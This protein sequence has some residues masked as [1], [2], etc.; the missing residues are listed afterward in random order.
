[1]GFNL[2]RWERLSFPEEMYPAARRASKGEKSDL[3]AFGKVGGRGKPQGLASARLCS[4][5]PPKM[6]TL[7][8]V[9]SLFAA[10]GNVKQLQ[11]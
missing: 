10:S 5:A 7:A 6:V 3:P 4:E 11:P 2:F 8:G 9:Y 1:V